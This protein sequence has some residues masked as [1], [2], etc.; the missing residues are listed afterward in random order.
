MLSITLKIAVDAPIPSASVSIAIAANPGVLPRFLSAYRISCTSVSM[1]TPISISTRF[2]R[3][4]LQS[5]PASTTPLHSPLLQS[6]R[7]SI[8]PLQSLPTSAPSGP[9]SEEAGFSPALLRSRR[10][11]SICC[12]GGS[13]DPLLLLFQL[14][15]P[16]QL[17]STPPTP[18][19]R[20]PFEKPPPPGLAT[21]RV[22]TERVNR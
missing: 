3:P 9:R 7:S 17:S 1:C 14:R 21:R 16:P 13:L 4:P 8:D 18:K 11:F 19:S 22:Y 10:L 12:R 5:T 15:T 2:D 20:Q 6:T